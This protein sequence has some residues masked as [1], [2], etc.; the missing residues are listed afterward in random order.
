MSSQRIVIVLVVFVGFG[1]A[2]ATVSHATHGAS[3]HPVC[4]AAAML[5]YDDTNHAWTCVSP[6]PV[7]HNL[8][9]TSH[10]DTAAAA[11]T[12]GDLMTGQS[13]TPAWQRLS[14]GLAGRY[15]RSDGTDIGYSAAAAET[16]SSGSSRA[17]PAAST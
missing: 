6:A 16:F 14:L 5:R 8:L 7:G 11:V 17:A 12:R 15:L 4:T 9:S 2:K 1:L 3:A 10:P 13:A